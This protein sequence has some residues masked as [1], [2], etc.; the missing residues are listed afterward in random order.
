[1]C[2]PKY[3]HSLVFEPASGFRLQNYHLIAMAV[4]RF[5]G[6]PALLGGATVHTCYVLLSDGTPTASDRAILVSSAP[7]SA[8]YTTPLF[9]RRPG[10]GLMAGGQA[11]AGPPGLVKPT[12][13]P[14][15]HCCSTPSTPS[16]P[17]PVP[18]HYGECP[19]FGRG[20]RVSLALPFFALCSHFCLAK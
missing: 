4:A 11:V 16:T 8:G 10:G 2:P 7:A 14:G 6:R 18:V 19:T 3:R 9:T 12:W 1:M 13:P 20:L 17:R 5:R 15:P